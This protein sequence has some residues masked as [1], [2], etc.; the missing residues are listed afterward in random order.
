MKIVGRRPPRLFNNAQILAG[1]L[2]LML[3]LAAIY[4]SFWL[5]DNRN[6]FTPLV[7]RV[8]SERID[9]PYCGG[10]GTLRPAPGA[11]NVMMCPICFGVGGHYVR[12]LPGR[13]EVL[14]PAC[15]GMGRLWDADM[16]Y[17]RYCRRCG[18][19]GLIQVLEAAELPADDGAAPGNETAGAAEP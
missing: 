4:Q 12:R 13:R 2:M 9:C 18:G 11:T 5:S 10:L 15:G 1:I 17:A 3:P 8:Q 16:G 19:R 14:C 7:L 6:L